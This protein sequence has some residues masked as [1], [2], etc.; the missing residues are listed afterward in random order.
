M[1]CWAIPAVLE[2]SSSA[3]SHVRYSTIGKPNRLKSV[4]L[5]GRSRGPLQRSRPRTV[6]EVPRRQSTGRCCPR[7]VV[8]EIEDG[9]EVV[10]EGETEDGAEPGL[11]IESADSG[12]A[13]FPLRPGSFDSPI[14]F[15]GGSKILRGACSQNREAKIASGPAKKINK[16]DE[17]ARPPRTG[18]NKIL[19]S[20]SL[21]DARMLPFADRKEDSS[22]N[23]LH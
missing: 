16:W 12:R 3:Y 6:N 8:A 7:D 18:E 17:P 13:V 14:H 20:Q 10:F 4:L 23:L 11:E 5:E 19:S 15:H 21:Q 2:N 1:A 22:L 9:V